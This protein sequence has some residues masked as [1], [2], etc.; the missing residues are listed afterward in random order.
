MVATIVSIKHR[1]SVEWMIFLGSNVVVVMHVNVLDFILPPR[2]GSGAE[3]PE[4]SHPERSHSE[5]QVDTA[6]RGEVYPKNGWCQVGLLLNAAPDSAFA[7]VRGRAFNASA[8]YA[9][10]IF[11]LSRDIGSEAAGPTS[12]CHHPQALAQACVVWS[13]PPKDLP[14]SIVPIRQHGVQGQVLAITPWVRRKGSKLL[15]RLL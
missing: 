3:R 8:L 11:F 4:Q 9:F 5:R 1:S 12:L 10:A 15:M 6:D 14:D 7:T 13:L 2:C